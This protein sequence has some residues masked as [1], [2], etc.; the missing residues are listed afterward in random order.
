MSSY[1]PH[2]QYRDFYD[3]PRAFLVEWRGVT[4]FFD[5]PFLEATDEYSPTY[6]VTQLPSSIEFDGAGTW[7]G[8][9]SLGKTLGSVPVESV[10]FDETLRDR[11]N[12][13]VFDRLAMH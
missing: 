4:Y 10:E 12:P 8:I 6:A 1:W 11:V 7:E 9:A 5:S 2:I 13:D 3:R